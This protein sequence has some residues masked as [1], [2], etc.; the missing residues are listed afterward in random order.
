MLF[1]LVSTKTTDAAA[2]HCVPSLAK[3][4]SS[5]VRIGQVA[6]RHFSVR[7]QRKYGR[8]WLPPLPPHSWLSVRCPDTESAPPPQPPSPDCACP[9]TRATPDVLLFLRARFF[10]FLYWFQANASIFTTLNT[11]IITW[12]LLPSQAS[13]LFLCVDLNERER[14]KTNP[15]RVHVQHVTPCPS[16]VCIAIS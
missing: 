9:T 16:R 13:H 1:K 6:G 12:Q 10:F 5:K 11:D 3:K 14:E 8:L 2:S 7:T 4:S 15:G